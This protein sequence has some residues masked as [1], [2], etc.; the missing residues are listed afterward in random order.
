MAPLGPALITIRG[1]TVQPS[2]R[3]PFSRGAYLVS[4]STIF[5]GGNQSLQYVNSTYWIVIYGV[6]F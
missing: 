4:F 3:M 2:L 1:A 5:S 6:G